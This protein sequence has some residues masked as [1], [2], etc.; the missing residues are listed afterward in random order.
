[1]KNLKI[2]LF[3]LTISIFASCTDN[4]ISIDQPGELTPEQTFQ[5]VDDLQQGLNGVYNAV[6]GSAVISFNSIF[7]D[8]VS[9]GFSN[10]NP[11][12]PL[13]EFNMDT[14]SSYVYSIWSNSLRII[15]FANRVIEAAPNVETKSVSEAREKDNV[16]AQCHI[17]RAYAH[18]QLLTYFSEDLT[19]DEALGCQKM[20]FVPTVYQEIPRS[21]NGEVYQLIN[22]DL[23]FVSKL[24][25]NKD[26]S[27]TNYISE[28]MVKALRARIALYRE[29]YVTALELSNQLIASYP[30]TTRS[31]S[32][33]SSDYVKLWKDLTVTNDEVIFRLRRAF[34]GNESIGQAW[35]VND[36]T[37]SGYPQWEMSTDLFNLLYQEGVSLSLQN[38]IRA[39]ATIATS[40]KVAE[41]IIVLTKYPGTSD[42]PLMNDYKVFRSSE[43]YFVKA[44]ALAN[45]ADFAGVASTLQEINNV[46]FKKSPIIPVPA[47]AKAAWTEILKQRRMELCFEGFRWVDLKR[48]GKKAQVG[49]E[50]NSSDCAT[51]NA[52]SLSYDSYKFTM[53]IPQLELDAN[54]AIRSQQNKGY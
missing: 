29:D 4:L 35:A 44:E 10:T 1:M 22:E 26:N 13:F 20:D 47:D 9:I 18:F 6:S 37:F 8:E 43:M 38:D 41:G 50:R 49:I 42:R 39:N 30:L 31:T 53:P 48:L 15:N 33:S 40:S 11:S 21:K 46:R 5:T 24:T 28:D 36:A 7:T 2:I 23:A 51:N 14:N 16:L 17:L 3:V 27:N 12:N 52:C 19:D 34:A 54:N 25:T 32:A 45:S